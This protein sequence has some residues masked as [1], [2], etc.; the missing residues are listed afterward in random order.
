M[1]IQEAATGPFEGTSADLLTLVTPGDPDWH[2]PKDWPRDSRAVTGK[3]NRLSPPLRKVGWTVDNLGRGGHDKALRWAISPPVADEDGRDDVR[4]RPQYRQDAG[5]AG[6]RG[7]ESEASRP[8]EKRRV[9]CPRH[10]RFGPREHCP[11]CQG[12]V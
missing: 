5:A 7:H 12:G 11:H 2:P 9:A 8:P 1:R 10:Q 4:K 3:M 6:A